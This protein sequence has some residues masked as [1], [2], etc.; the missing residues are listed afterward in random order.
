MA[1]DQRISSRCSIGDRDKNI[2]NMVECH[3]GFTD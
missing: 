3:T 2:S 1:F